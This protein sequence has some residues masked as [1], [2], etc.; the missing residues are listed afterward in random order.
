MKVICM[1]AD[2]VSDNEI[3]TAVPAGLITRGAVRL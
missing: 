2:S 3:A 1:R